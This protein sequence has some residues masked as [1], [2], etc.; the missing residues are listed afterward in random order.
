MG[1]VVLATPGH[2]AIVCD[3]SFQI[4]RGEPISTPYCE[5]EDL[6]ASVRKFSARN[7][8]DAIRRS[9]EVKRQSCLFS[10]NA[11][12]QTCSNYLGD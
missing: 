1:L 8:G 3:G 10:A 5:D 12:T 7:S 2:A 9:S 6:A 11:S 4:V